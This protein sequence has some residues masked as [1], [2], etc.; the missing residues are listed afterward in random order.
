[1]TEFRIKDRIRA[2]ASHYKIEHKDL[3]AKLG[4]P[5]GTFEK[6]LRKVDTNPPGVMLIVMNG[7]EKL[8]EFRS[9]IG[10]KEP[11]DQGKR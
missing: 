7:L 5:Y 2:F 11:S 8:P 1:M 3:A 9:L 6:W 10:I 4:T